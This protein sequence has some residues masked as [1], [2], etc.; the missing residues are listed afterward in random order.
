MVSVTAIAAL[1]ALGG[2]MRTAEQARQAIEASTLAGDRA[3]R[4]ALLGRDDVVRLP[5]S[6]RRGTFPPPFDRFRWRADTRAADEPELFEVVITVEWDAG[7]Y[8]FQTLLYR[9]EARPSQPWR[10]GVR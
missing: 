2:E 7:M 4:I 3:A 1:A 8:E 9:P 10:P 6:L 5:D